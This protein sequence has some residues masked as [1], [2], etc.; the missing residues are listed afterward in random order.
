M[1]LKDFCSPP[2]SIA[3]L[4]LAHEFGVEITDLEIESFT[5]TQA[6]AVAGQNI[7]LIADLACI[8]DDMSNFIDRENIGQRMYLRWLDNI[9]PLPLFAKHMLIEELEYVAIEFDGAPCVRLHEAGKIVFEI[10]D[11]E[12]FKGVIKEICDAANGE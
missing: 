6:H 1:T 11:G 3:V 7:H 9:D 10:S 8:V 2:R 12:F 5:E 4:A